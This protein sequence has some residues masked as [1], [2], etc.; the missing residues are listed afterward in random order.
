MLTFARKAS[1]FAFWRLLHNIDTSEQLLPPLHQSLLSLRTLFSTP[2][3]APQSP[4]ARPRQLAAFTRPRPAPAPA[5]RLCAS[6]RP[7]RTTLEAPQVCDPQFC[8]GCK[9]SAPAPGTWHPAHW[10]VPKL[11]VTFYGRR[12][13]MTDGI[14]NVFL[15]PFG[16][17]F[18]S[19]KPL[20]F[21]PL[22]MVRFST[23]PCAS[24]S[25]ARCDCVQLPATG[26]C[27]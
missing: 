15:Q 14:A 3:S 7:S 2:C 1:T 18:P 11:P 20:V 17:T 6:V 22:N 27:N 10:P 5:T 8:E 21:R 26:R 25:P 9:L 4:A 16:V 13:I 19:C 24:T 23:P 12:W